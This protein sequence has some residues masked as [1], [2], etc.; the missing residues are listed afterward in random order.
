MARSW[1][2]ALLLLAATLSSSHGL[3]ILGI[4]PLQG[5]SHFIMGEALMR[6]L[7]AKGHRVDVYSHF[8]LKKPIPNY[9]DY[10]LAG[11]L[12]ALANNMSF[13]YMNSITGMFLSNC[14]LALGP[15]L[16]VPMVSMVTTSLFEWM[17]RPL[18]NP[19]R[20]AVEPTMYSGAHH[21]MS[22]KDRVRNVLLSHY[23]ECS[24]NAEARKSQNAVV[25]R[26]FGPGTTDVI[27]LQK[28]ISLTLVNY[29]HAL[30]GVRAFTPSVVPVGG[31][32]IFENED[33]VLP[34]KIKKFMDES[35]D[36]F[37]YVSFGSMVQLETFPEHDLKELYASF[38]NIAPIRVVMKIAKPELLPPG[39]PS[40]VITH[41][42]LPQVQVLMHKTM[43]TSIDDVSIDN[44]TKVERLKSLRENVKCEIE[45][46][47]R[48]F[49]R[50]LEPLISDWE[51]EF[52]NLHD[53]FRSEEIDWLLMESMKSI[54][55]K[56]IEP[57][58]LIE[59]L[60]RS[61]YT[62][63]PVIDEDG[64][65]LLRRT[66]VVHYVIKYEI[67]SLIHDLVIQLFEIYNRFD[68]NYTDESGL[69]HFHVACKYGCYDVVEKFLENG[70][71]VCCVWK[72]TGDTP[73]HMAQMNER[74]ESIKWLLNTGDDLLLANAIRTTPDRQIV[75]YNDEDDSAKD[76][77]CNKK[78]TVKLLLKADANPTLPNDDGL[79]PLHLICMDSNAK[80]ISGVLLKMYN[81]NP[82]PHV[83][84]PDKWGNTPLHLALIWGNKRMAEFLLRR[85]ADVNLANAV[86]STSLHIIC[87]IGYDDKFMVLFFQIQEH[88]KK[89]VAVD[90]R[91]KS[92][93]TPLHWS[94]T[95]G[96]KRFIAICLL[97]KGANPN[98]ANAE[99]STP[100]HM[101][102]KSDD[103]ELML[104]VFCYYNDTKNQLVLVNVRD[105]L[106]NTPLHYA[107]RALN[108]ET[109][110][111]VRYL[112]KRG[113]DPNV[114]N[115]EGLTP[116]QIICKGYLDNHELACVLFD[117]CKNH[118]KPVQVNAADKW[119][120]TAL[121]WAV[122]RGH[123]GLLKMLLR[124]GANPNLTDAN[125]LTPLEIVCTDRDNGDMVRMLFKYTHDRYRPLNVD[126]Q[127]VLGN[128]PL[129]VALLRGDRRV[130]KAL[131]RNGAN[132]NLANSKGMTPLHIIC[133]R[134]DDDNL[135]NLLFKT[136]DENQTEVQVN[137]Q[138][139]SG[140]TPLHT[141]LFRGRGNLAELLLRRG[142]D[143][144]LA[145][146]DGLTPL[147][148]IFER[149]SECDA[150][151]RLFFK[152]NDQMN[153]TVEVNVR[154]D[155]GKSP[156]HLALSGRHRSLVQFLLRYGADP[157][158][159]DVEGLTPLHIICKGNRDD[160]N[161]AKML[162]EISKDQ[163][164]PIQVDAREMLGFT[165]L[166]E[167][168]T[169]GHKNLVQFLLR[170]GANP[171]LAN[172]MDELTALHVLCRNNR[173]LGE[174]AE[175]LFELSD[176]QYQ[177]I[178]VDAQDK[179]G[180]T[181]LHL[182][183]ENGH[184]N[185]VLSM[186][187]NGANPNV[188][189][190]EGLTPLCIFVKRYRDDN[191]TEIL[192]KSSKKNQQTGQ[193]N[194]QGN[195]RHA[196]LHI[197]RKQEYN[198]I[199]ESLLQNGADLNFAN[200]N[201]LTVLHIFCKDSTC[202]HL[203]DVLFKISDNH[204]QTL[205]INARSD[206]GNTPLHLALQSAT[207]GAKNAAEFLLRKGADPN[208]ANQ[209]ESTPL[210]VICK[211]DVSILHDIHDLVKIFF[212]ICDEKHQMLQIDAQDNLGRTPLQLAVANLKPDIIDVLLDRGADLSSF[213]FPTESCFGD[214]F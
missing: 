104:E 2:V 151:A 197:V 8:P 128:A 180:N 95:D 146:G 22:F 53:I 59:F 57:G 121:R 66:T 204:H 44:P 99:G 54:N 191:F 148:V 190:D 145:N 186:L 86:G 138:D 184:K 87:K 125:G 117:D 182:A 103:D 187:R 84:T 73:L 195:K 40:N 43:S 42:W 23:S 4:F 105:E 192:Y 31:I 157:N 115:Q 150:L 94:L 13:N 124:N 75:G 106:G 159:P 126:V 132:P 200:V 76:L 158:K 139:K 199:V 82:L 129:Y 122:S 169:N 193:D 35:K 29:H 188:A 181:P 214:R 202:H 12:P 36:G 149:S 178:Q 109:Q 123:R 177:P 92:G 119:G 9:T 37:V 79:T 111:D 114:A 60:L 14:Y 51:T 143:P 156:L 11:T 85:G 71:D 64:K 194:A 34:V 142:A 19:S 140:K 32:H 15:H 80:G 26:A 175:I 201:G 165:P 153:K 30:N 116:L 136:C 173:D 3:R 62:D 166:H 21:P 61:G 56:V 211:R 164:R 133:K 141:A 72:K 100:L 137:A 41:S 209:E 163:Y 96:C 70:Q 77:R 147:H 55:D 206:L 28:E 108:I 89:I 78:D 97:A 93:N 196:Q 69:S 179:F 183:L 135:V 98:L 207:Q 107:V 213:V 127:D 167:A 212:D 52:P 172:N 208:L 110:H 120:N 20:L 1:T 101:I 91:D 5:K 176:K 168:L 18:G 112:M 45:E 38:K 74:I 162:F 160:Y 113:A 171:N 67:Y 33:N 24:F 81:E 210:H 10:S 25:E 154:D 90:A 63:K 152:I 49:L 65:P 130:A 47:R 155:L 198:K 83:D 58:L 68:L 46:E 174:L 102:F 17:Y 6:G 7:A 48:E 205:Q 170:K 144:N 131:L 118:F 39:L 134:E 88:L 16:N 185:L 189:N 27:D 50:Q 203:V 161:L